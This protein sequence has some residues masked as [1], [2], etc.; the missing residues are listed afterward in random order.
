MKQAT[1]FSSL[2]M[3]RKPRRPAS[4]GMEPPPAVRSRTTGFGLV[5]LALSQV[6]SSRLGVVCEG[7]AVFAVAFLFAFTALGSGS[8]P[9]CNQVYVRVGSE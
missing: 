9:L 5:R 1:E 6:S 7:T 2:A 3:V 8:Q 4:K